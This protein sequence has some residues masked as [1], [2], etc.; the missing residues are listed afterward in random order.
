MV[1]P[2]NPGLNGVGFIALAVSLVFSFLILSSSVLL[3]EGLN[4]VVAFTV[5]G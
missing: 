1:K 3:T 5:N 2:L 4:G